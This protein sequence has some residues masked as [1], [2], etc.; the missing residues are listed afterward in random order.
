MLHQKISHDSIFHGRKSRPYRSGDLFLHNMDLDLG[1]WVWNKVLADYSLEFVQ[2]FLFFWGG[3]AG[4]S[5]TQCISK[6]FTLM[7][8]YKSSNKKIPSKRPAFLVGTCWVN[9]HRSLVHNDWLQET[10]PPALQQRWGWIPS[11]WCIKLVQKDNMIQTLYLSRVPWKNCQVVFRWNKNNPQKTCVCF[12]I[13]FSMS[14]LQWQRGLHPQKLTCP[15][16][17]IGI[18][19]HP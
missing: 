7:L 12:L 13:I 1:I 11:S 2:T 18:G 5:A 14:N 3:A 16:A 4:N 19:L 10:S 17:Q 9:P 15:L 6:M 8:P